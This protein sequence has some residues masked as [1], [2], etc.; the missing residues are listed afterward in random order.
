MK[1]RVVLALCVSVALFSGCARKDAQVD[2]GPTKDVIESDVSTE[3]V[4]VSDVET[5]QE[6]V[7]YQ[8]KSTDDIPM[9]TDVEPVEQE[10]QS[11]PTEQP[12]VQEVG[13]NVSEEAVRREE[14]VTSSTLSEEQ[15]QTTSEPVQ[16]EDYLQLLTT[17]KLPENM[18]MAM[19]MGMGGERIIMGK[20]GDYQMQGTESCFIWESEN[21]TFLKNEGKVYSVDVNGRSKAFTADS[22]DGGNGINMNMSTEDVSPEKISELI[23]SGSV[24]YEG[25]QQFCDKECCA[26]RVTTEAEDGTPA[27]AWLYIEVDSNEVR[28]MAVTSG[29]VAIIVEIG[30]YY[31]FVNPL[32]GQS[33]ESIDDETASNEVAMA[34][35]GSVLQMMGSAMAEE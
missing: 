15:V 6:D 3:D 5:E 18:A 24:S 9:E 35:F 32:E 12:I 16:Q 22:E 29:E 23:D 33:S 20:A 27:D 26:Y 8:L 14:P 25:T 34:I 4:P 28:G 11:E 7:T 1:K 17:I 30:D 21:G 10:Q 19:D 31:E 13:S 2:S